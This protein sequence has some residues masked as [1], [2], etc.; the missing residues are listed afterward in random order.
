MT[1]DVP[2]RSPAASKPPIKYRPDIDSLRTLAVVPVVH[3]HAYPHSIQGGFIGENPKGTFTNADFYS[4][5][6]RHIIPALLLVL[7]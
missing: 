3:F 4:R 1:E 7:T 6:I 2:P 5:R